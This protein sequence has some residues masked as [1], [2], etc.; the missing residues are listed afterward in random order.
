MMDIGNKLG[1]RRVPDN[2]DMIFTDSIGLNAVA[3]TA[4]RYT[5]SKGLRQLGAGRGSGGA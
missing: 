4:M 1:R 2:Q 5:R 3:R